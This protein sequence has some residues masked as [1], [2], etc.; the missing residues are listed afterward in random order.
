MKFYPLPSIRPHR[1]YGQ[2]R[3]AKSQMKSNSRELDL[4]RTFWDSVIRFLYEMKHLSSCCTFSIG[5]F[6]LSS[7]LNFHRPVDLD[8]SL[9]LR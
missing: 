2:T 1:Y 7:A 4:N 6:A 3:M 5:I 8:K 9:P